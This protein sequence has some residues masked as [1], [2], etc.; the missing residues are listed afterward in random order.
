METL[1]VFGLIKLN[2]S[3]PIVKPRSSVKGQKIDGY[4]LRF[5][6]EDGVP[7]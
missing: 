4:A 6:A 7:L 2:Q 5:T 3:A 1:V